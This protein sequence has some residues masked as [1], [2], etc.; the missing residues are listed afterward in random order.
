MYAMADEWIPIPKATD[1]RV[2]EFFDELKASLDF[3][4]AAIRIRGGD[5]FQNDPE[6]TGTLRDL[7]SA[8]L[9]EGHANKPVSNGNVTVHFGR[10]KPGY[11]PNGHMG[12]APSFL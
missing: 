5:S 7:N 12:A 2:C 1:R 6:H 3:A 11:E 10:G 9:S 4:I 8:T